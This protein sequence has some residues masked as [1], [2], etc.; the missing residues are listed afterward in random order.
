MKHNKPQIIED[1]EREQ[2]SGRNAAA[3]V[4]MLAVLSVI[5]VVVQ[6]ASHVGA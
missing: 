4:I 1:M 2:E 5:G 3:L 6:I